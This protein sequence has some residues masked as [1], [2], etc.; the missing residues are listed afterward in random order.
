[1]ITDES[2]DRVREAADILQ[3]VGEHVQLKRQGSDWRGPCPFHQG[4]HRNFSVSPKKGIYYCFVCHE[5][6]DVFSFVQKRLGMD[7]P[8][9]VRYVAEKSGVEVKEVDTRR[10]REAP[11]EREPIWEANAAAADYFRRILWEDE[12]GAAAR[13]YLEHRSIA[14]EVADRFGLGFAPREIGLMRAYLQT[15][16]FDDARQLDAGLLVKP[17]D[18]AEVR[19]RFRGRLM[20]PIFD[21]QGRAIAFGGRLIAP[22]EPKYLNSAETKAFTKGRTL[23]GLNWARN[24]IRKE[25]RVLV[26]E[27]YFDVVRLV[28]AGVESVVAP[29]GTA[30]TEAQAQL[31][32]RYTSNVFLLYDS[33]EAGLKATFRSGLE[34]LSQGASVRVVTLP[35]GEDPDTFVQKH[36][37]AALEKQLAEAI[38]VFDRQVQILERR[39]WFSELHRTRRAID[40]LLPTIRATSDPLTRDIY[41]AR[42]AAAAGVEKALVAAEVAAAPARAPEPRRGAREAPRRDGGAASPPEDWIAPDAPPGEPPPFDGPDVAEGWRPR[43]KSFQNRGGDRRR[44]D[45]RG[46]PEWSSDESRPRPALA[47]EVAPERNLVR[48]LLM[49]RA[50]AAQVAERLDPA[51]LREP[52]LREILATLVAHGD[53]GFDEIQAALS[54][55]AAELH[56]TLVQEDPPIISREATTKQVEESLGGILAQLEEREIDRRSAEIEAALRE[57]SD[58]EKDQLLREKAELGLRRRQLGGRGFKVFA[59]RRNNRR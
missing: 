20:F 39:G 54:E 31:L 38:D 29:L 55:P 11:D 45:R 14:R 17:E 8:S 16:G 41:T 3:I 24:A 15:L 12:L 21:A 33:D 32:R 34:L 13:A 52:R 2:V 40:K 43:R 4:T 18:H 48:L 42:L 56:V 44:G 49:H 27:G 51:R 25:E 1:V 22:G 47:A 28:A 6:G 53:A 9:A 35:E 26:V 57:A 46:E 19:P 23:Y 36:G 10:G 37:P 59:A 58:E 5:G 7:W 50:L 30:L